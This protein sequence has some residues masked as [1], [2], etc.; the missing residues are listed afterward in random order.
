M[1]SLQQGQ[2]EESGYCFPIQ[3]LQDSEV[4]EFRRR[5]AD[6]QAENRERLS[7]LPTS[8]QYLV[9]SETHAALCGVYRIVT[10]PK[11]L[12]AVEIVLGPNLLVWDSGWFAKMPGEKKYVA[13][14]QDGNYFG[15]YPPNIVT[16]WVALIAST[17]ENGCLRV[18]PGSHRKSLIHRE[19]GAPDNAL[20][21][22]QEIVVEVDESQAVDIVLQPGELSLHHVGIVHGSNPNTSDRPRI[23]LAI[24]YLTPDVVHQGP[25]RQ[26]A[27]LV[28]GKDEFGYWGMHLTPVATI[29]CG[30]CLGD[31]IV[32]TA[33]RIRRRPLLESQTTYAGKSQNF[34]AR[35]KNSLGRVR[36]AST[37]PS[38][39][40]ARP[41][42]ER[43]STIACGY[44]SHVRTPIRLF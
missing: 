37:G 2:Y 23:G 7:Q 15:L 12:D 13:W 40:P 4:S 1:A 38:R 10:H 14:H 6:Y 8:K 31:A 19:A 42:R 24:R 26:F 36:R 3:A 22:G 17:P 5:F 33:K 27:L 11:V 43:P 9:F 44:G 32:G 25:E 18:V 30:R 21:R 39:A 29:Y 28:R 34:I 20:S 41:L 35:D 16:A